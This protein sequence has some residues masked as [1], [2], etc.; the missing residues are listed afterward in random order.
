MLLSIVIPTHNRFKYLKQC[1]DALV[2]S[3]G[4]DAD[5]DCEIMVVDDHSSP[6]I[7]HANRTLCDSMRIGYWYLEKNLGAAGARNQGIEKSSG[8]WIAFLDDDVCVAPD[9]RAVCVTAVSGL[10]SGT[11]GVEGRLEATG[12]G[13]WDKEVEVLTGKSYLTCHIIYRRNVLNRIGG[14]DARF[15]SRYPTCED[16]ELATRALLWGDIVFHQELRARHLPRTVRLP[17]YLKDSFHRMR[18]CLDAEFHFYWKHRDRY[19]TMRYARTFWGTYKNIVLYHTVASLKRRPIKRLLKHPLQSI[20]LICACVLE[21]LTALSLLLKYIYDYIFNAD[22]LFKEHI[23]ED[24]TRRLWNM[25]SNVELSVLT[26]KPHFLRSLFFPLFRRPVYS[27]KPLLQKLQ[28]KT[29]STKLGIFLRIDDVFLEDLPRVNHF[30][31]KISEMKIKYCAAITG[32]DLAS[33]QYHRVKELIRRSG[34]T[35]ALHG[36]SHSGQFGPYTSELLQMNFPTIES[37]L[38]AAYDHLSKS[39][40]PRIFIPPY[41]A[42]N[43]EQICYLTNYF[44]VICGGPE[45]A[46]F[47]DYFAG[48]LALA[49]HAWYVPSF[50]PFYEKASAMLQSNEFHWCLEQK[51]LACM[52]LHMPVEARDGFSGLVRLLSLVADKIIPWE[53]FIEKGSA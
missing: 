10:S 35:I 5:E 33:T 18:T 17:T 14:F 45:T 40:I 50:F 19:H 7:A 42:I 4:A 47:T 12:N 1:L 32:M 3:K 46:R 28:H 51:G 37:R 39:E 25:N 49:N 52:T 26:L 9:W 24:S 2:S 44:K 48:P 36:F 8:E 6:E 23:M 20:T 11:V 16:H 13:V 53:Y 31:E 43:R 34:G 27:M 15:A 29:G 30:C 22:S 38:H 41:N 21:Q